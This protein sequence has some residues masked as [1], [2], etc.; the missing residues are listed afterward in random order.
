MNNNKA[1]PF[2][3]LITPHLELEEDLV[4]V[5]R[6]ALKTA[7]FIGGPMV[8][9]FEEDF[10]RYCGTKY[11]VG[12]GSGTDALRFSLMAAG[13]EAGDI[14]V[15]VP[16]TFIATTEAISQVG[17]MPDFV[18][19]DESTY[20]MNPDK[21]REYLETK[22]LRINSGTLINLQKRRPVRAV[23]PVHLYGRP[24]DMDPIMDLAERYNLLVIEDACQAHGAEY[25]SKKGQSW[26]KAGSMGMAAAFS[27]YPGKNLGACGE[28]G[29]VTTN[30][31]T[32]AKK[33]RMIRDH[34]QP[35]KYYHDI[36][37]YNGRLDAIQ[38]GFLRVKLRHLGDWNEKRREIASFYDT[39]L[40]KIRG[41]VT[42][43]K[44]RLTKSVYHLYVIRTAARDALQRYLAENQVATGSHYP[45]PLHLQNSYRRL[46][47][48]R[49][50]F[51]V[52]ESTS[53]QIMSLPMGPTLN[54]AQVE[55]VAGL[56]EG[57]MQE[58]ADPS[59]IQCLQAK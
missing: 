25:Y 2:L 20:N 57:F 26:R 31:E 50:S 16:N 56:I 42:P 5:F 35:K 36:E 58:L 9:G 47:L 41:I 43:G 24:A 33:I 14:V 6:Q 4:S 37:G 8:E 19:I 30:N 23:I 28:A 45:V 32:I 1:V 48:G 17:A 7:A 40:T 10:A 15:T 55:N 12:V 29:A 18:D 49:G 22:C 39:R 11:C 46:K 51:P 3:D 21:L 38:A 13:I 44:S 59:R 34:G 54:K 27:F 53:S 52:T